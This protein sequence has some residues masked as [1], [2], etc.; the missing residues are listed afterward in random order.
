MEPSIDDRKYSSDTRSLR[1]GILQEG[2]VPDFEDSPI[3]S[4]LQVKDICIYKLG[5]ANKIGKVSRTSWDTFSYILQMA[6][7]TWMHIMAVQQANNAYI[8]K[9]LTPAML[10]DERFDRIVFREIIDSIFAIDDRSKAEAEIEKWDKFYL[11]IIGQ[12]GA[13]GKKTLNSKT[14]FNAMFNAPR[15][16][17]SNVIIEDEYELDQTKLDNLDEGKDV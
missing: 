14:G 13:V 16:S 3:S 10:V 9:G 15:V 11:R 1:D 2:V 4:L 8:N 12:R 6:H 7:N 5:A 17:T